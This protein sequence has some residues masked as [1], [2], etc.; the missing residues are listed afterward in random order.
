LIDVL[1]TL[2]DQAA[3]Y[4]A[5]SRAPNTVRAYRSDWH[6]FT[7]WCDTHRA[8][9]LPADPAVLALYLAD[10]ACR[11]KTA[12][13]RR[14]LSSIAV[15][16]QIAGAPDPTK[17]ARVQATWA[18]IRRR[19][20]TAQR[21][22]DAIL[23]EDLCSMIA[24]LPES[25]IGCRDFCLLLLG[26]SG[27]LRRREL[28]GLDLEDLELTPAGLILTIRRSK[29]DQEAAGRE[30]GVPYGARAETCPVAATEAWI[31][32]AGIDEGPLFR[33]IDRHGHVGSAR[34]SDKAVALVVK[35]T[36]EA[37]GLDPTR[38]AGHSLRSGMATSAARAGASEA[39]IANQTGHRSVA[40]LRRYIRRGSLFDR[41]A[42]SRLGL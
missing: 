28:V 39:E 34:L 42:A 20:G 12:T 32:A 8:Q 3:D 41:N 4:A 26:F 37:A 38:F 18:G 24:T 22:K 36:A 31:A 25:I 11:L 33:A 9:P 19:H 10:G 15:A 5:M 30:V 1:A 14:H 13:L 2:E 35:R 40:V 7:A 29:T 23:T 16:H 6:A 17:D 27:A 21:G